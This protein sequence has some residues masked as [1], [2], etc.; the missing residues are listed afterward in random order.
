VTWYPAVVIRCER[1]VTISV[2]FVNLGRVDDDV[3]SYSALIGVISYH[4]YILFLCFCDVLTC[5]CPFPLIY[6]FP[7]FLRCRS[8][9][10][11]YPSLVSVSQLGIES[12]L[13]NSRNNL[14]FQYR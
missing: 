8:S 10:L 1:P 4:P 11:I 12:W 14:S 3:R 5:S 6:H 13:G 7:D 9:H 2:G